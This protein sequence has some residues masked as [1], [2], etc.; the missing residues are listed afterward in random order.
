MNSGVYTLG[1]LTEDQVILLHTTAAQEYT[2][3]LKMA[4]TFHRASRE[5]PAVGFM[6]SHY[7]NLS[8]MWERLGRQCEAVC[9]AVEPASWAALDGT[10]EDFL[11]ALESVGFR[12][13]TDES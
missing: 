5:H 8:A 6:A 11:D 7:T 4:A 3:N 10:L 2:Q 9:A 1:A 13:I 12:F